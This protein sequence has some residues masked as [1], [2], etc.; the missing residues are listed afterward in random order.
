MDNNLMAIDVNRGVAEVSQLRAL[1]IALKG[2]PDF[3]AGVDYAVIPGTEKPSL[4]Q[5]GAEK[6]MRA[7]SVRAEYVEL[8]EIIVNFE[9]PLFHY[10]Y[11][12]RLVHIP[13]GLVVSTAKGSCNSYETKYR[14]RNAARVCP[15][16]G[17][18]AIIKGKAEYGGGWLCYPKKGGCNA[19]FGDHDPAITDQV[20]GMVENEQI[21]DQVNTIQKIAQKRSNTSSVKALA[22]VS[23]F[24]TV[25]LEDSATPRQSHQDSQDESTMLSNDVDLGN[26][27]ARTLFFEFCKEQ[28]DLK[29]ADV[30][31][32]LKEASG[33]KIT[34][35][36]G[37]KRGVAIQLLEG[38]ESPQE[39]P[40][41]ADPPEQENENLYTEENNYEF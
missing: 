39:P 15:S 5:P 3:I 6:I 4:L 13:T 29:P 16:C 28:Y 10:A 8:P 18:E 22:A 34:S 2:S 32:A 11:E 14:Y 21:Y 38:G 20:V 1:M 26:E 30:M 7:L 25:D 9:K 41:P 33:G 35:L 12:C 36:K 23:E 24:F 31:A 37:V 27:K 40:D 19:K 17:K